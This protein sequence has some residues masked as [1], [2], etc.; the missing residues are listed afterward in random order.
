[1]G[2]EF[3]EVEYEKTQTTTKKN[4]L[5][6]SEIDEARVATPKPVDRIR[7]KQCRDSM[8]WYASL[9]GFEFDVL[10]VEPTVYK[11]REPAGYINFILK[12]DAEVIDES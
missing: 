9:I 8:M 7:I 6:T 1:M 10:S 5:D 11:T 4:W 3:R 12:E 2:R